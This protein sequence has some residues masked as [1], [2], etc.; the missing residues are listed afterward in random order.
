M[1]PL[2]CNNLIPCN[3]IKL[4]VAKRCKIK[5][6]RKVKKNNFTIFKILILHLITLHFT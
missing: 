2:I 1:Y 6:L 5:N 4:L 3:Y